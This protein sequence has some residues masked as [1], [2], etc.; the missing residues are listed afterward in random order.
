MTMI[1]WEV[2]Q[3]TGSHEA[4]RAHIEKGEPLTMPAG[5]EPFATVENAGVLL[6][7]QVIVDTPDAPPK[8]KNKRFVGH[9]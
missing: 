7:R 6:R 8:R 3:F 4:I 9:E 2:K 1:R 5:W